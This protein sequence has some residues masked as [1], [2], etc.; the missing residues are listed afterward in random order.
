MYARIIHAFSGRVNAK[1]RECSVYIVYVE[2]VLRAEER[3]RNK[4]VKSKAIFFF[5]SYRIL[6]KFPN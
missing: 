1:P 3:E 5:K 4:V 6:R 2:E